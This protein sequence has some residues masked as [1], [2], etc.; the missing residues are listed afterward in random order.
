LFVLVFS[1]DTGEHENKTT[2]NNNTTTKIKHNQG[3]FFI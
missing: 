3:F 1:R 2:I